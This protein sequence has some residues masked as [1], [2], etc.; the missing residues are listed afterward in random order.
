MAYPNN[1]V[2]RRG[3]RSLGAGQTLNLPTI[4]VTGAA[5]VTNIAT[6]TFSN[7]VVAGQLLPAVFS[8]GITAGAQTQLSPTV[9]QIATLPTTTTL[10]G[11]SWTMT[12]NVPG[13]LGYQG[14]GVAGASGTF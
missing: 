2:H 11:K 1:N 12:A 6:F 13:L 4:T 14:Q 10:V 5:P 7:N 3:R 8:G 9:I